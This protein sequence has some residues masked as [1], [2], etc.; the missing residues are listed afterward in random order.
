MPRLSPPIPRA[1]KQ[2]DTSFEQGEQTSTP[3]FQVNT[4]KL[5]RIKR[6]AYRIS[7]KSDEDLA[8]TIP[9]LFE[10]AHV[11]VP[12]SVQ[13][14]LSEKKQALAQLENETND[15]MT[16]DQFG[17]QRKEL[18]EHLRI[19][20]LIEKLRD[21][22][23]LEI[24]ERAAAANT[25]ENQGWQKLLT[26]LKPGD[27]LVSV[28]VPSDAHVS[29]KYF[30][31][32]LF[33]PRKTDL[34]IEERKKALQEIFSAQGLDSL[35]QSYKDGYF[36][37]TDSSLTPEAINVL[38]LQV[39]DRVNEKIL[40]LLAEEKSAHKHDPAKLK[41]LNDFELALQTKGYEMTFGL[42]SVGEQKN[43]HD[44]SPIE[45][46]VAQSMK[47][48]IVAR[49]GSYRDGKLLGVEFT[50]EKQARVLSEIQ[51][52]RDLLIT[53]HQ[54][55]IRDIQGHVF[56]IF[57]KNVQGG[58]L[59]L[60]LDLIR[61]IRKG[62]FQPS[63]E[64]EGRVLDVKTYLKIINILDVVKPFTHE[65]FQGSSVHGT[66]QHL[67]EMTRVK[68]ELIQHLRQGTPYD[69]ERL[70]H[71]LSSE[72]KDQTCTSIPEFHA[73][74]LKEQ[75]CTYISIDVLDVGPGLLQE[76]DHLLAQ[77]QKGVRTFEDAAL[78][79]GDTTTRT[80]RSFRNDVQSI[81]LQHSTSQERPLMFVGGDEAILALGTHSITNDQDLLLAL[82]EHTNSRVIQTV[83]GQSN[84]SSQIEHSN[85]Q[86]KTEH[87]K[88]MKEA[89]DGADKAKI[90]ERSVHALRLELEAL[91][92]N[93]PQRISYE[94]ELT[95]F[96]LGAYAI[97]QQ[98]DQT[99]VIRKN[100]E[101]LPLVS[102]QQSFESLSS[103]IQK[104]FEN[105]V[106]S[107]K[108][109][110]PQAGITSETIRQVIKLENLL[111][112]HPDLFAKIINNEQ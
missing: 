39:N 97:S 82:R 54:N 41:K 22:Q 85:E 21:D 10:K 51:T 27:R 108:I 60:N 13:K 73:R 89:E 96:S 20:L 46:A 65:E 81:T 42:V 6:N 100:A 33:G 101:P 53:T 7:L 49:E 32:T 80:M 102:L 44:L 25:L 4:K 79:A 64:H 107:Y 58:D 112:N 43:N 56:S 35:N 23:E 45:R 8:R 92:K 83:V 57:I 77:V 30:N 29:I 17:E 12:D 69:R 36:K 50:P 66:D 68:Q 1:E 90:I 88:A 28:L 15:E 26:K 5:L 16:H 37:I 95:S 91:P 62:K 99:F 59:T 34:I 105:L 111:G 3:S 52:Q 19:G 94:T 70:L 38:L 72:G 18:N 110:Y 106:D 2:S 11:P 87:M 103:R 76:F 63:P 67:S 71:F 98:E 31:D 48:A 9:I 47:G 40:S 93:D 24:D 86:R 74:A 75:N 55:E 61:D 14:I 104:Q 78:H 84:R 109:R